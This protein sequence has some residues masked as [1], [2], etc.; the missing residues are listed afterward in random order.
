MA[1]KH[2]LAA[3]LAVALAAHGELLH[4]LLLAAHVTSVQDP[5][6][7][8]MH[9]RTKLLPSAPLLSEACHQAPAL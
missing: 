3:L 5:A 6:R 8:V 4:A 9:C 2:M 7:Q 1:L